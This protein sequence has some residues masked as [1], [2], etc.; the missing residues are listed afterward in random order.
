VAAVWDL[1]D[2][3]GRIERITELTHRFLGLDC[4]FV[5]VFDGTRL[6]FRSLAGDGT[7]FNIAAGADADA[8]LTYCHRLVADEIPNIVADAAHDSRVSDLPITTA[9]RIG[10][11]I[12]VPIENRAGEAIGTLCALQHEANDS[13][14]DRD[15]RVLDVLAA[16]LADDLDHEQHQA[17]QHQAISLLIAQTPFAIAY[18]PVVD[19]A[20]GLILGL[21]ALARFPAPFGPPDQTFAAAHDVGLGISLERV[22]ARQG[23]TIIPRLGTEQFVGLNLSPRVLINVE[24]ATL[25]ETT[26]LDQVVL[27]ITEHELVRD[28]AELR[29]VLDRLR[30][31]GLRLAID[32]AG[33]GFA[34]LHHIVE[35]QPDFIKIDRSLVH[36]VAADRARRTVVSSFR[37]LAQELDAT[38]IAEGVEASEDLV[39]LRDLGV[40]AAQGYLLARPSSDPDVIGSWTDNT[41]SA[42][43]V[44]LASIGLGT[45]QRPP[46]S[47]PPERA[48]PLQGG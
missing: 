22:A 23:A 28:Y 32:D 26:R 17:R 30:D 12:G 13:L 29:A 20:S 4:A 5:S 1:G 36:G 24:E 31:R 34:S 9:A 43:N 19:L 18:Q 38:V 42:M 10:T 25:A 35:L 37:L 44:T 6:E 33:A 39:A 40:G 45:L 48:S 16:L 46:S 47:S 3:D 11:Y 15:L 8:T 2:R 21:E 7:S 14:N 27:E 41:D